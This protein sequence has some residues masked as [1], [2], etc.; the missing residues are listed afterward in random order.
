MLLLACLFRPMSTAHAMP[1]VTCYGSPACD[2]KA[3]PPLSNCG[4][5]PG[6][7]VIDNSVTEYVLGQPNLGTLL[8]L[9]LRH[10]WL[11]SGYCGSWWC[12]LQNMQPSGGIILYLSYEVLAEIDVYNGHTY[13]Q[14]TLDTLP[15]WLDPQK[16]E[17][18]F[19]QGAVP[20]DGYYCDAYGTYYYNGGTQNWSAT[21]GTTYQGSSG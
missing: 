18:T 20:R 4:S 13:Y 8:T 19:M 12:D 1:L 15:K 6:A 2:Y 16:H 11:N 14:N 7:N 9:R 3:P 10:S 17:S 21:S 5:G